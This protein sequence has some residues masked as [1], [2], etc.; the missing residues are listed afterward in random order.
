MKT[1]FRLLIYILSFLIITTDAFSQTTITV[2][3]RIRSQEG[4]PLSGAS[5]S[6]KNGQTAA[7]SNREGF[8]SINVPG[9]S[10]LIFT[11][12]GYERKE[13][14]ATEDMEVTLSPQAV[15]L[16]DVEI[17]VDKGYGKS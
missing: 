6:L 16:E 3:G 13:V 14:I 7:T 11:Y 15:K 1:R 9:N 2:K 12:V 5:I 17:V 4:A 8:F 10:T